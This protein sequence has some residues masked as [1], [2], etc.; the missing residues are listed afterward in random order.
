VNGG[1][2]NQEAG[3]IT[4]QPQ[5]FITPESDYDEGSHDSTLLNDLRT[6]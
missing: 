3:V 5:R 1:A 2:P 6:F 4:I